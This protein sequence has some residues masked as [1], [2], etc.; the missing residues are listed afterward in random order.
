MKKVAQE[1]ERVRMK[2]TEKSK[3]APH[4]QFRERKIVAFWRVSQKRKVYACKGEK[5]CNIDESIE[6]RFI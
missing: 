6:L 3:L 2:H 1:L 4:H 5:T